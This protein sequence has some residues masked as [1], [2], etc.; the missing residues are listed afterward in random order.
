M[1]FP[2]VAQSLLLGGHVRVGL[3]DNV[4]LEKGILAPD[5]AA[6]VKKA[7]RIVRDLGGQIA[8]PRDAR[9][10]LKMAEPGQ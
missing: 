5:N 10:I 3:E 2:M 8:T 1:A 6:L 4:Y 9:R 7:A